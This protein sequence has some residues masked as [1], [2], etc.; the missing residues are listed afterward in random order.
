MLF[1]LPIFPVF[2]LTNFANLGLIKQIAW[3]ILV[4]VITGGIYIYLLILFKI[5]SLQFIKELIKIKQ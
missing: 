3:I 1:F 4:F 2:Y 5:I